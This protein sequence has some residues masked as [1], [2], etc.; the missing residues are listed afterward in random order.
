MLFANYFYLWHSKHHEYDY[1]SGSEKYS[2][3]EARVSN[4][5]PYVGHSFHMYYSQLSVTITMATSL[6]SLITESPEVH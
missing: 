6:S 2:D 1:L 5:L 4:F 3:S